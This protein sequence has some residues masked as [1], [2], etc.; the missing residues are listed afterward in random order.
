MA[1]LTPQNLSSVYNL[2]IRGIIKAIEE[3]TLEVSKEIAADANKITPLDKGPLRESQYVESEKTFNAFTVEIGYDKGGSAPYAVRVH[4][5]P[6]TTNWTTS[7]T[8]NKYL[9][10]PFFSQASE[11]IGRVARKSNRKAGL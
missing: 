2:R 6:S 1:I 3:S 10:M 7:G 8:S 4:E 11:I 5:L 9:Q